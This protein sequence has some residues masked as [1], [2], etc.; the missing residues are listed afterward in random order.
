MGLWRV[1]ARRISSRT[2]VW[3]GSWLALSGCATGSYDLNPTASALVSSIA[4]HRDPLVADVYYRE[5]DSMDPPTV[6]V[7][8][9]KSA[10]D[11]QA[12]AFICTV[13]RPELRA[14]GTPAD[15]AVLVWN[16]PAARVMADDQIAC[17]D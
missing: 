12:A 9:V 10:T 13:V 17:S 16:N 5:G 7:I 4:A 1:R 11:E 2:P 6:N 8:A 14:A 15:L 3:V